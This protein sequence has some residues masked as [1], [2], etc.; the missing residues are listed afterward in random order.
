MRILTF[1][2]A[3][4]PQLVR[5]AVQ[6]RVPSHGQKGISWGCFF[7]GLVG[8]ELS[9]SAATAADAAAVATDVQLEGKGGP[10]AGVIDSTK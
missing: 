9:V 4:C 10:G 6:R 3:R 7:F 5:C 1:P 2:T 8:T